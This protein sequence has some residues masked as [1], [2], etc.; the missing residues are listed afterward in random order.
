MK[1]KTILLLAIIMGIITTFLFFGI[2]NPLNKEEVVE[3]QTVQVVKAKDKIAENQVITRDLVEL[4]TVIE[5]NIPPQALTNISDVE[6]KFAETVIQQGEIVI[7]PRIKEQQEETIFVSRKVKDGYRAVSVGATIVQS[8]TN[9]LEPGDY[10]DI[11]FSEGK[12]G[13][14]KSSQILS[15]VHVLAVGRKMSAPMNDESTYTEY[16]AVTLELKPNDALKLVNASE[17]GNIH[18]TLHPSTIQPGEEE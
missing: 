16:S 17:R 13:G 2:A 5:E 10:V 8:V 18:F 7:A 6:G 3:Q 4:E 11:I 15:D 9:L 12:E 14:I 1:T